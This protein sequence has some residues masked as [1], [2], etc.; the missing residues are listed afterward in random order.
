MIAITILIV[1]IA[2]RRCV[3]SRVNGCIVTWENAVDFIGTSHIQ[4]EYG[5]H[6]RANIA[7]FKCII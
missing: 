7:T 3:F 5:G 2:G 1:I 4:T 6:H